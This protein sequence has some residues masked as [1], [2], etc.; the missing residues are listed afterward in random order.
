MSTMNPNL[1]RLRVAVKLM[2]LVALLAIV[3]VVLAIFRSGDGNGIALMTLSLRLP[4]VAPGESALLDW[5]GRPVLVMQRSVDQITA[6]VRSNAL[7]AD[8]TSTRSSQPDD[9]VN[10]YRSLEPEWF[11][12]IALGTDFSCTVELVDKVPA[13]FGEPQ[14][15]AGL[16][17]TC[18]GSYYD[19]AGRVYRVQYAK[20]NLAVPTYRLSGST[21]E[22][23]GR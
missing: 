16:R 19:L 22:L 21:L 14:G 15:T 7:L 10:P 6:L 12:A 2:L 13:L 4:A 5:D 9:A 8:A 3:Y 17:D 1:Q 11:V 18:R 20:K 23:V